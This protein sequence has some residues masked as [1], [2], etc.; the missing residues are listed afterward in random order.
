MLEE[1]DVLEGSGNAQ[2]G[3]L[4]RAG[5]RDV[6]RSPVVVNNFAVLGLVESADAVEQA[7]LAGAVGTDDGEYFA[8]F[9]F[10]AYVE[11][12]SDA[13]EAQLHISNF[14]LRLARL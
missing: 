13:A 4:V 6:V 1:F 9:D 5:V 10:E 14:K 8:L 12:R 3:D 11:Q 7:G 2:M